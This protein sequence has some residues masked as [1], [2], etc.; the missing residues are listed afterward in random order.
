MSAGWTG[1]IRP[2]LADVAPYAS[3]RRLRPDLSGV[4]V[5]L[6]A[7]ENGLGAVID[8]PGDLHRYPDP[9]G[10]GLR[11]ALAAFVGVPPERVWLGS[12]A[13]D[14][15]DVLVRTV[16]EPGGSVIITVPTYE[17]YAQRARAHGALPKPVAL[18]GSHDLDVDRTVEA[19]VDAPLVF[20]CS[21]N[22]PTGNRLS[23][24]RLLELVA[25][26]EAVVAVDEAYVEF[27]MAGGTGQA[28]SLAGLA[29]SSGYE[30]L[31]VLRTLSKAW[32]LAGLRSGYAVGAPTLLRY[33]DVV[34]LPYRLTRPSIDLGLRALAA[35]DEMWRR[36]RATIAERD[37][38]AASLE[39]LGLTVAPS[40]TNYLLFF[41]RD[42][43]RTQTELADEHGVLV[44]RR[45]HL[46]GLGG[47][48]RV[49]LG[50]AVENDRFLAAVGS[51]V[52]AGRA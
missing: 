35:E 30:R 16:V 31:I 46:P 4:P 39:A 11:D 8:A 14:A 45:D 21:P 17:V 13:D 47:G 6:D 18:D 33:M 27:A 36:C 24:D 49:T 29:G 5:R 52:E 44:R 15:I 12:G 19:A 40:E 34:G 10:G 28:A 9:D 37:R 2:H 43:E 7:N 41:V 20:V 50:T 48:L 42:A 51:L 22:N 3:A 25:R 23:R 1:P 38:V 32:G 26:T